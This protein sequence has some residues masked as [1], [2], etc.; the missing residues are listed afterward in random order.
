MPYLINFPNFF[1]YAIHHNLLELRTI[2]NHAHHISYHKSPPAK[3]GSRLLNKNPATDWTFDNTTMAFLEGFP[4]Q[5]EDKDK[6]KSIGTPYS[7]FPSRLLA[8]KHRKARAVFFGNTDIKAKS[9]CTFASALSAQQPL[10]TLPDA[11]PEAENKEQSFRFLD[12]PREIR[13]M[14][15]SYALHSDVGV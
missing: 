14:I 8:S 3:A 5:N 13:D 9:K 7:T 12:F 11:I 6:I 2:R 10:I 15:Y 4:S 1:F